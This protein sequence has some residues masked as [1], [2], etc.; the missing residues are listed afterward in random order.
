MITVQE[1]PDLSTLRS[2]DKKAYIYQKDPNSDETDALVILNT[3]MD[4]DLNS[5]LS[6]VRTT[7]MLLLLCSSAILFSKDSNELVLN[8]IERMLTK[9]NIFFKGFKYDF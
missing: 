9:V 1:H 7:F 8:P 6:I 4:S 2:S 3:K 5:I